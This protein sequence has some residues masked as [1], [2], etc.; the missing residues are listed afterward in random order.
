MREMNTIF[1]DQAHATRKVVCGAKVL[2]SF[3]T[4]QVTLVT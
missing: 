1:I 4:P 3:R 2:T